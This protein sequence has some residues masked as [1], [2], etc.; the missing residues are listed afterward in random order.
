VTPNRFEEESEEESPVYPDFNFPVYPDFNFPNPD[1]PYDNTIIC[2]GGKDISG[3]AVFCS[4]SESVSGQEVL[5]ILPSS[6]GSSQL[7]KQ[8]EN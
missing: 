4:N 8:D 5:D 1:F 2:S 6:E 3:N 7:L